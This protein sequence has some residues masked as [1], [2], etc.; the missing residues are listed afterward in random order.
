M[1]NLK[2]ATAPEC[3]RQVI[4]RLRGCGL[5]PL[6]EESTAAALDITEVMTGTAD[7]L[8][9][10]C[11]A[12]IAIGGDGAIFHSAIDALRY[13]KP[14]LG[15]NSGRLGFLSQLEAGDLSPLERLKS[16]DY[17]IMNRMVLRVRTHGMADEVRYAINDVVMSRSHLGRIID[18]E[19]RCGDQLVGIYRADGLIFAT[20]TGSTA[21]SLSA[22][23]PIVDPS[24]ES[25]LMTPTCP[26][27]LYN[28]S[29]VFSSD[30]RLSVRP[31]M[32]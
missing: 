9:P 14:I 28:R 22:G 7:Q 3:T 25:I 15:I 18:L 5:T 1:P 8:L 2:L 4:G 21:Y 27:S 11:D 32:P 17:S 6:L 23:G 19:V 30:K 20:P 24:V 13:S 12:L 10:F 29:I 26:H 16:G 31:T